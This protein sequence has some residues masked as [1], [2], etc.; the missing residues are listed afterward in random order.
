[1]GRLSGTVWLEPGRL[2]KGPYQ[3]EAGPWKQ[4]VGVMPPREGAPSQG[5][6]VALETGN[7]Q[8]PECPRSSWRNLPCQHLESRTC[9]LYEFQQVCFEPLSLW[10][11]AKHR[12]GAAPRQM[13]KEPSRAA[14]ASLCPC[15]RVSGIPDG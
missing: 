1:M 9:D 11:S 4:E 10:S 15:R 8:E 12:A 2:S 3:R 14:A 13:W 7:G 5:A 6:Q